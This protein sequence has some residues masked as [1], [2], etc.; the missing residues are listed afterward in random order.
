MLQSAVVS[1]SKSTFASR[2]TCVLSTMAFTISR[3]HFLQVS[4]KLRVRDMYGGVSIFTLGIFT[5]GI[6]QMKLPA[7]H[8]NIPHEERPTQG[9]FG[10][11]NIE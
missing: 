2:P 4:I 8:I 5:Q 6:S 11:E 3:S 10:R 1:S 7:P 9:L